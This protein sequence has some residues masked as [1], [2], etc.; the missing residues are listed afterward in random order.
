MVQEFLMLEEITKNS[1]SLTQ[2]KEEN[3]SV[4]IHNLTCY[5]DKVKCNSLTVLGKNTIP[6]RLI[7]SCFCEL[8]HN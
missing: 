7:L 4:E 1:P 8:L 6:S 5:W 2:E 3:A